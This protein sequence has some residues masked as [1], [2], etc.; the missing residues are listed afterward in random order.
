MAKEEEE[1]YAEAQREV[2]FFLSQNNPAASWHITAIV[3]DCQNVPISL[4]ARTRALYVAVPLVIN[5]GYNT[6]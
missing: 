5:L 1:Y 4:F 2:V 6:I 3:I